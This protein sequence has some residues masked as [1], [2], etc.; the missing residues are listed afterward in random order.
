MLFRSSPIEYVMHPDT[1]IISVAIKINNDATLVYFGEEIA[2][3][4]RA[5]DWSQS[6]AVGHNMAG[7]DALI[8]SYKYGVNPKLWACT[9]AMARPFNTKTTA[10][11]I[12]EYGKPI[13]R[14]GVSLA[15]LAAEVL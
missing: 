7:F 4:L 10:S 6:I 1:E 15:K 2:P 5:I 14:D 9:A 11:W 3:A 8:L 13:T 12:D